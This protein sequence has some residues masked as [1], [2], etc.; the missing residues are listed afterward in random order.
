MRVAKKGASASRIRNSDTA[1]NALTANWHFGAQ[2]AL[3]DCEFW[4]SQLQ[5]QE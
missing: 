4:A 1:G 2:S 5:L 3:T